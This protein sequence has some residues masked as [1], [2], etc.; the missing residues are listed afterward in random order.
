MERTKSDLIQRILK[1]QFYF[2]RI[3]LGI[4]CLCMGFVTGWDWI[5]FL[6]LIAGIG[7]LPLPYWL[8]QKLKIVQIKYW[9]EILIGMSLFFI[10]FTSDHVYTDYINDKI[11]NQIEIKSYM[12]NAEIFYEKIVSNYG[13][14]LDIGDKIHT[15]WYNYI[16]SSDFQN[17]NDAINEIFKTNDATIAKMENTNL[18]IEHLYEE[19]ITVPKKCTQCEEIKSIILETYEKYQ[20]WYSIVRNPKGS[21]YSYTKKFLE[22]GE[23]LQD[24]LT[25]LETTIKKY[26]EK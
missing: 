9:I 26:E 3:G 18:K 25:E 15:N 5:C 12:E 8:L 6:Y 19:L 20:Q 1:V 11:S 17:I 24:T 22:Y 4:P 23:E 14:L 16:Y 2:I 21:F 10:A 7:L 13:C